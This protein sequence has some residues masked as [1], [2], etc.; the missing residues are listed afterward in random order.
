MV[1]GI[2]LK[3]IS[4]V[5]TTGRKSLCAI[6]DRVS[7]QACNWRIRSD[8]NRTL[9]GKIMAQNVTLIAICL[10][11]VKIIL[12]F[13]PLNFMNLSARKGSSMFPVE[14]PSRSLK[15]NERAQILKTN[16]NEN[17]AT[18]FKKN[19]SRPKVLLVEKRSNPLTNVKRYNV[20]IQV[21]KIHSKYAHK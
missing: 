4:T 6:A 13:S 10:T 21:I 20:I 8:I 5:Y 12:L 18:Q 17:T 1:S 2:K 3:A 14:T 7:A 19:R 16:S 15:T 11:F 9:I